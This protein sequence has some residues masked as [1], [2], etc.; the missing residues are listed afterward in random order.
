MHQ[1]PSPPRNRHSFRPLMFAP[2]QAETRR[3]APSHVRLR[4]CAL[5][6]AAIDHLD[7]QDLLDELAEEQLAFT[8]NLACLER[9]FDHAPNGGARDALAQ[10]IDDLSALHDALED[11]EKTAI[12]PRVH[13]AYVEG[14][15]LSDY[16]RGV[17]AWVHATCRALEHLAAGLAKR[18]VDWA[19]YR[20][21]IEE[22]KNFHFDELWPQIRADVKS[23]ANE[24]FDLGVALVC[25]RSSIL[26][27]RLGEPLRS[28]R[29]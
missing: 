17:Y 1:P 23:I 22:A 24:D 25:A 5:P 28:Q 26:E 11:L 20:W 2:P 12:D 15:A 4:A 14:A 19:I 7:A 27:K 16:L 29:D 21:R 8:M 3:E 13:R 6:V 18:N 9:A 10:R